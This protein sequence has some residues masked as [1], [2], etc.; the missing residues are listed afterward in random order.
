[1]RL[2]APNGVTVNV[3]DEKAE[4]LLADN[5]WKKAGAAAKSKPAPAA[6]E[7]QED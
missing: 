4:R 5:A 2:R 3:S 6:S 7:P 1:M